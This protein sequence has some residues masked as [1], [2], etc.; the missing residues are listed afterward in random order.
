M[1][2]YFHILKN[3]NIF[4]A[5][6]DEDIKKI[7]KVCMEKTFKPGDIIIEEGAIG[8]HFYIIITGAVEIFKNYNTENQ[9]SLSI[10]KCG[11]S[12]GELA[13]IDD[14][15]RSA[16]VVAQKPT[17]LLI[18][19]RKD[20][21]KVVKGSINIA[22]SMMKYLSAMIR[23]RTDA[24]VES[25]QE[26]NRTLKKAYDS[27]RK[28]IEDRRLVEKQLHHQAFYDGLTGLPNRPMFL[29]HLQ[30]IMRKS[31]ITENY[32]YAVLYMDIDRFSVI[33]ESMGHEAGDEVLLQIGLRLKDCL[34]R[35]EIL[36][37]FSGD[38][39]ALLVERIKTPEDITR[40]ARRI[41]NELKPPFTI[42]GKEI[43]VT[44][45]IGIV[46]GSP[47]YR[48]T[49]D[50]LRDADIAM[51]GAKSQGLS[52]YQIYNN[53]IHEKTIALLQLE[54]DIKGAVER[55]EFSLMYQP[56]VSLKTCEVMG[57][58]TLVRWRHPQRGIISPEIFIPIAEKTGVILSLGRWILKTACFR[59]STWLDLV[60]KVDK[61]FLN[62]NISG[63]QF[64]EPGMLEYIKKILKETGL[65]GSLIKVELTESVLLENIDK[66]IKVLE[67]IKKMGIKIAIDDF[68]T[69]Y[70]S[71]SYLYKFPIDILKIDRSFIMR[72]NRH[73]KKDLVPVIISIARNMKME[74]VA[75]G[76]E[77]VDQ[78]E[79][80]RTY[81]C[82][83]G[84]GFLFSKPLETDEVTRLLSGPTAAEICLWTDRG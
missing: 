76:I 80:L 12:F 28:E 49:V 61:L 52:K 70:S 47:H 27:L 11:M 40:V 68:G 64:V 13:L 77:T 65:P 35:T 3:V 36:A 42:Y 53:R 83:Y 67:K 4:K 31:H 51:Y 84:Q 69:G 44:A 30:E 18:I 20:F 14:F 1:K 81:G 48:S 6:P 73:D 45:C 82:K 66:L 62:I 23:E 41:I 74:V 26:R 24:F 32:D 55:N 2:K 9:D 16:T 59:M 29:D 22:F 37:R 56:I 58:E 10:F 8:R 39:F 50:I 79:I 17:N 7:E 5:L 19:E 63:K 25:L 78:L 72:M 46:K 57:F 54:T 38:E 60:P 15:P 21:H 34:R 43:F 71:L 75:E 33:N